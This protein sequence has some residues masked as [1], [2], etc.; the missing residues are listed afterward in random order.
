MDSLVPPRRTIDD[1]DRQPT[2]AETA[3]YLTET[4]ARTASPEPVPASLPAV[5]V[6][7][8]SPQLAAVAQAPTLVQPKRRKGKLILAVL[9][10][11]GLGG[12][13]HYGWH[14]WTV[15]RFQETTDNA[16]LQADKVTV[17]PK[18]A[19]F[20]SAVFVTDNQAVKTGDVLATIDQRDYR[21]AITEAQADLEKAQAQLEGY[22]AAVVQQE[23]QVESNKADVS[24]AEAGV[25]FAS[26]EAKRYGDLLASGAGTSQRAQQTASDLLQRTATLNKNRAALDAAE[27]QVTTY[28]ALA[29]SALAAIA[30]AQA[31][32]DK[33][34]LDM[35]YTTIHAPIDGV[36]GDRSLRI[37]QLIQAGTALLTVVPTGRD[38]YLV[39][40]F[41]ETQLG[42]MNVGQPVEFTV[43]AFGGHVFH[44]RVDS[45]SPGTGAQFA[46]LPPENATGNFTKVVQRV[47]VKITLASDDAFLSRLRPGLSVEATVETRNGV[48]HGVEPTRI[49]MAE[50]KTPSR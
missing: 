31:K 12:G 44:G 25:T 50:A 26:Q 47:P 19:G 38:I 33:A 9:L 22:K 41:K 43:D 14:W 30:G 45:F 20:V 4:T 39:A 40:N 37:G 5:P 28:G 17:A 42:D 7:P 29:K 35:S 32:L 15:G 49:G 36:V 10:L 11:A 16:Y 1:A 21:L 3:I 2:P 23:A 48:S 6:H 27:K 24:N 13:G 46:L 34:E 18:V 8:T